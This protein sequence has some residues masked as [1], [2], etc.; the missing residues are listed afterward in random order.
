MTAPHNLQDVYGVSV[1]LGRPLAQGRHADL[2]TLSEERD[3][4]AKVYLTPPDPAQAQK[5][6]EMVKAPP[7]PDLARR[8]V[9]P[10]AA[11][12]GANRQLAGLL[13]P[14][15]PPR[16]FQGLHSLLRPDLRR[17]DFPEADW[18]FAV[19]V[20]RELA[21][22]FA[23][24]HAAG[25][26]MGDVRAEHVLVSVSGEVR[27]VGADD[28]HLRLTGREFAGPVASAEYLPPER[29]RN[30]GA[31]S[32]S[33]GPESGPNGG[34]DA[35]SDAFGLAVLLFELLLG[36]HPYAGIHA[37]GTAPG[38][39]EAIAAG[40]FVDSPQAG[41][42]VRPAPGEWPF[43]AL[44]PGVQALFVQAFAAP[45]GPRPTPVTWAVA[46]NTFAAELVPCPRRS[47][48]WQVPGRPCPE[49]AA[50]REGPG[51]AAD[52][53]DMQA[54]VQRL[55]ND[56]QRVVAPPPAPP[57]AP[58][59]EAPPLP[60]L[61]LGLP[62]KPRGL[63]QRQQ[64]QAL[65][66]TLRTL[67]LTAL[68]LGVGLVQRSV[69]AGLVVPAIVLFALTVGRRFAVDWDGLIDRYERWE[70]ALVRG[71][72]PRRSPQQRYRR[73]VRKRRAEVKAELAARVERREALREQYHADNAA[74]LHLR[75]QQALE[76]RRAQLLSLSAGGSLGALLGRWRERTRLDFL[77]GQPLRSGAVPGLGP[78]ELGLVV[79]QGIRTAL[80]VDA[81]RVRALPA[82]LGRELLAWRR[83][84]EDF[85]QFDP[86]VVPRAEINALQQRGQVQL[87]HELEEFEQAVRAFTSAR[88]DRHEAEI[89][90]QLGVVEREIEQYK[91]ALSEL[92]AIKV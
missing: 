17:R 34:A 69:L 82:P 66:W 86:G 4:L 58:V 19:R 79:A 55:W 35:D 61:P 52:G 13:L 1:P 63:S 88:W 78:R 21:L 77:R 14:L 50:E 32:L 6:E 37:R 60:P 7:P 84:L 67:V 90:Q 80:E 89:S 16:E 40:L 53:T 5:V 92:R 9:W 27:L 22:A 64:I 72:L 8:L 81:E 85:F 11:L 76:R 73:A 43:A 25:H 87:G 91:K 42:G 70:H 36:R 3:Q 30:T 28:Y 83:S 15:L 2:L 23:E 49:C 56:V 38:P 75:E 47:G 54:R 62:D 74:A 39:A 31:S 59:T 20:G 48:H 65:T 46:L 18:P 33:S 24:L 45:P 57:V 68:M 41:P 51:A 12:Y 29:Q 44:P 71:L 26:W 10:L